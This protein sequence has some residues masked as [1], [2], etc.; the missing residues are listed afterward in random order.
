MHAHTR[1]TLSRPGEVGN[2]SQFVE[3]GAATCVGTCLCWAVFK[4]QNHNGFCACA[5]SSRQQ[6]DCAC[7][8]HAHCACPQQAD[9]ACPQQVDWACPQQADWACPQQA[10]WACPQ[11][12]DGFVFLALSSTY[13]RTW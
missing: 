12:A 10:D 11:Q 4:I 13:V 9:Y 7:P 5:N 8:Q 1:K 6:A 3:L 2:R